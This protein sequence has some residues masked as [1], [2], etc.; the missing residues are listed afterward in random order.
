M[1]V[2]NVQNISN[3]VHFIIIKN[4]SNNML[5]YAKSKFAQELIKLLF[6]LTSIF[7]LINNEYANSY[8][9]IFYRNV[10]TYFIFI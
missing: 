3:Y 5:R 1:C 7:K 9:S 2:I 10:G 6:K 8:N 4:V